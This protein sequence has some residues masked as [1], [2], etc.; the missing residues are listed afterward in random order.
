MVIHYEERFTIFK[1]RKQFRI[2]NED[3][4]TELACIA[5]LVR[6]IKTGSFILN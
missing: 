3:T 5:D 1:R 2:I 6:V 4:Y